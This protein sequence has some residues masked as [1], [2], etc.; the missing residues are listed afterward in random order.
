MSHTDE[1]LKFAL[2]NGIIDLGTIQEKMEM[3]ERKKYL[4]MQKSIHPNFSKDFRK[5]LRKDSSIPKVLC[6]LRL[7]ATCHRA[8]V[9]SVR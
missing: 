8:R 7:I 2:E 4:N 9:L 5:R 1:L 3:N 6:M